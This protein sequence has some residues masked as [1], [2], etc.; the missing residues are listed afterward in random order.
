MDWCAMQVVCSVHFEAASHLPIELLPV[1]VHKLLDL[2]KM[3]LFLRVPQAKQG[4]ATKP[5]RSIAGKVGDE[6]MWHQLYMER[7]AR[8]TEQYDREWHNLH[9]MVGFSVRSE[10]EQ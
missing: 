5:K 8:I 1:N 3:N 4:I 9:V 10:R 6:F 7:A 2:L